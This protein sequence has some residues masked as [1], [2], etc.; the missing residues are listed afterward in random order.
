[1]ADLPHTGG[2]MSPRTVVDSGRL[3]AGGL[4]S[5]AVAALAGVV[6][7]LIIRGLFGIPV[8]APEGDGAWGDIST[9]MYALCAAFAALLATGLAHVLIL[10]TPT[11]YL[12]FGWIM[13]LSI[14]AAMVAPFMSGAQ[15]DAKVATA[16]INLVV[17]VAIWC[18]VANVASTAVRRGAARTGSRVLGNP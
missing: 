4:A 2:S 13:G 16:T 11:P 5:A 9:L 14:V 18:L 3:W 6:G 7:F 8:L 15:M 10:F 17:G 1:M 12:F